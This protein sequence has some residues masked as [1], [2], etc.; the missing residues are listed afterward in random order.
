MTVEKLFLDLVE[1]TKNHLVRSCFIYEDKVRE[2]DLRTVS[3][4]D[5]F[6][7]SILRNYQK[8]IGFFLGDPSYFRQG[9]LFFL[10]ITL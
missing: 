2:K 3:A 4:A 9:S 1:I 8:K 10:P 7:L 5:H 6:I